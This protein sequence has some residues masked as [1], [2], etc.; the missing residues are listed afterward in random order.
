M[1]EQEKHSENCHLE[2]L[3]A[4]CRICGNRSKKSNTNDPPKLCR[5]YA[6]DLKRVHGITVSEHTDGVLYSST[7]CSK[8]YARLQRLKQ[9]SSPRQT[10]LNAA[11]RAIAASTRVWTHYDP[12][13]SILECTVCNNFATQSQGGRPPKPN[14]REWDSR[15]QTDC[16]TADTPQS[17][18]PDSLPAT[19]TTKHIDTPR[20]VVTDSCLQTTSAGIPCDVTDSCLQTSVGIPCDVTDS[21][22]QTS[23]GIPCDVTDSCL[24]TSVGI[25]CDVTDSCLQTT[26]AGI[27]CDIT[28]SCLQTTSVGI[29]PS[30]D[31]ISDCGASASKSVEACNSFLPKSLSTQEH[32]FQRK[33]IRGKV[34]IS[35]CALYFFQQSYKH[36][37]KKRYAC[38]RHS[39]LHF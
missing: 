24:Q 1:F 16:N 19:L 13:V 21:C 3:N 39:S 8:C 30:P 34:R 14:C 9:A 32:Q 18:G 6:D 31:Q 33:L 2:R 11:K 36:R 38:F 7:F 12:S 15:F 5:N 29:L 26:S 37:N 35:Q 17:T 23:V 25:P 22:L 20:C 28:D 10:A 4:L 27:P